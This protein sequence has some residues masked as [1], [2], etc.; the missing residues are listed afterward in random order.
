MK[1]T[2]LLLL[3]FLTLTVFAQSKTDSVPVTLQQAIEIALNESPSIRI[4][5][6]TIE[7]KKYYKKE[8]IVALF[9]SVSG[10][11]SYQRML[12]KQRMV[13]DMSKMTSGI[14][15]ILIPIYEALGEHGII[16]KPPSSEGNGGPM[17]VGSFNTL[18]FSANLTLPIIMPA[19]WN[20]VKLT[21][22]DIELAVEQ[23]RAS[24]IAL[25]NN[26]K[27]AYYA[28]LSTQESYRVYMEN[29]K[30]AEQNA[31]M[32]SDRFEQGLVSEFEKL[33]ADVQVQSL[34]PNIHLAINAMDITQ[35]TLKVYMGVNVDEPLIIV[36]ELKDFETEMVAAKLPEISALSLNNNSDLK[37]MDMAIQQLERSKKIVLSGACPSLAL[38]GS[39]QYM[40]M[41]DD[42]P[43][44]D[45]FWFPT[46]FVAVSLQIPITSW[47]ST[48]YK[49]KQLKN[50]TQNLNDTR[51]NTERLLWLSVSNNLS[52]IDKAIADFESCSETVKM[53]TRAHSIV[54]KQYDV[55]LATWLD[56]NSAELALTNSQLLYYQS[57]YDYLVAQAELEYVLGK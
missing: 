56:L 44:K 23:A 55:G 26:V 33:R 24:K 5:D 54:Q 57:I 48:N 52:K 43:A 35:K 38:S 31:Q 11:V 3:C 47:A 39:F 2:I 15:D 41:G 6:R 51:M 42:I 22:M 25:I 53:A 46:S 12:Q 7:T 45:L 28:V 19:L 34:K 9:P 49:I 50:N 13:M 27:K 1:K 18:A 36:G 4:A 37:Q 14:T 21:S 32:I 30:I 20:T 8:Q 16:V 10:G 29:Y 40:T 17:E